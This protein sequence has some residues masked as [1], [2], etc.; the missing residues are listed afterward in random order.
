VADG[1]SCALSDPMVEMMGGR[2]WVESELGV[3]SVFHVELRLPEEA[4][5]V[6]T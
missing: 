1:V 3:G 4:T 2:L 5:A 6:A